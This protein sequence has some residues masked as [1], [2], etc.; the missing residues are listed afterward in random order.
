MDKKLEA[1]VARLETALN[2]TNK[3]EDVSSDKFISSD[4]LFY[5]VASLT[6]LSGADPTLKN[7]KEILERVADKY[8]GKAVRL[9]LRVKAPNFDGDLSDL[10]S[11][12]FD[13]V[14]GIKRTAEKASNYHTSIRN[15]YN[16]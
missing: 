5:I 2:S 1:R 13:S 3:F 6:G 4:E 15:K 10:L 11:D 16:L 9:D 7:E 14:E 12:I 8:N